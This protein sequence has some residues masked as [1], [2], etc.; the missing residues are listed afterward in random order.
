[1][2]V[3]QFLGAFNDNAFKQVVLLLATAVSTGGAAEWVMQHPLGGGALATWISPQAIPPLLFALPFVL[4]GPATGSMADRYSK[5]TIIRVANLLE[6]VVM[7]AAAIAFWF[8]DYGLLLVTVFLM[9]AQSALFGPSKYGVIKELVGKRDLAPANALIQ[10]S[11]MIAV[12]CGVFVGGM[13]ADEWAEHLWVTGLFYI[14][15][16]LAGWLVSLLIEQRPAADPQRRIRLNPVTEVISHWRD[17]EGQRYL[18]LAI[19]ASSFFYL[20]AA[21]Y[22][23]VLPTYGKWMG[24]SNTAASQLSAMPGIGIV[25]GAILAGRI[26]GG[27]IE[28]GL[29]PL[30]LFGMAACLLA[31]AFAPTSIPFVSTCFVGMGVSSGLFTIPIRC[32]I[33]SLP[34]EEKRGAVQ[35][36]AE[37]MDFIGILAAPAMFSLWDR[38]LAFTPPT[39]FVVGGVMIALFALLSLLFAGE[40]FVR[41]VLLALTHTLYRLRVEGRDEHLPE[42]GG[43]L[44]VANHVSFI[45]AVLLTAAAG[46]PIRFLMHRDYFRAPLIGWFARRMGAIPISA[47]DSREAL[48]QAAQACRAGEWVGIFAEG[49]ITRSGTLQPFRR[50]LEQIARSAGV[51]IFPVALDRLWGSIFSF[52]GGRFFWK[53]PSRLPYPVDVLFGE[54]LPPGTPARRVHEAVAELVA[55]RRT[56]RGR[57]GR[58]LAWRFVKSAC[59]HPRAEALVDLEG[60]RLTYRRLLTGAGL[61]GGIL[62]RTLAGDERAVGVLLPPGPAGALVN[63]ALPLAGRA[64]VNVNPTLAPADQR[65]CLERAG[66]SCLVTSR[67]MLAALGQESPLPERTLWIEELLEGAGRGARLRAALA[68]RLPAFLLTRI[69][70]P[71]IDPSSEVAT[72]LFSSGSTGEPK[73]VVL[74]HAAVLANVESVLSVFPLGR[75]DTL[76]GVLPYF[77]SFGYT[78]GLWA[79]L[80]GGARVATHPSPLDARAID[81]LCRREGVTVLLAPPTFYQHWMRRVTPEAFAQVRA[82]IAGAERLRPELARAFQER[83]GV[84]LLEGYGCTEC[85]PVVA[86]NLPDPPGGALKSP[87]RAEGTVGRPLPGVALRI[88]DPESGECLGPGEEGLIQVKSPALMRGY[89]EDG[90]AAAVTATDGG[91]YS[92]GDIGRLDGQGFLVLTDRLSRFSKIGGEMVPHGRVEEALLEALASTGAPTE[93][94]ELAVTAREDAR[95][96]ERLIVV[97]TPVDISPTE[98]VARLAETDLPPLFRPAPADFIPVDALP[99]LATGKLDQRALGKL[100]REA[101]GGRRR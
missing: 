31:T 83:F 98:W 64:S 26:S 40:F 54:A 97:H 45:D 69:W 84:E 17:T 94:V 48:E 96:G 85:G 37:V 65:R 44:I 3:S 82:A 25:I 60:K 57:E 88:V 93:E 23:I 9:G 100:A 46:R 12:L 30:G 14:A 74:T 49:S 53:M 28:G 71:R 35:G 70:V 101:L 11:T 77:H 67:R 58:G 99:R 20:M 36:L 55:E 51:P 39:M 10:S 5:T 89:L 41:L 8:E 63:L 81:R 19:I 38:G 1:M 29:V 80:L 76:L 47:G 6:V 50:G 56:A 2:T 52:R 91:W 86:F 7:I 22:L 15:F 73:G 21:T 18:V 78:V 62:R 79:A 92:T 13:L 27:R 16:A 66:V 68:A 42:E 33:Q 59:R 24:L 43:G 4:F 72:I 32:L 61:L 87:L 90:R 95:R 75:G 34:R